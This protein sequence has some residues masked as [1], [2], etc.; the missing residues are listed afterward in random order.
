[1]TTGAWA[2]V[3]REAL[4]VLGRDYQRVLRRGGEAPSPAPAPSPAAAPVVPVT[5]SSAPATPFPS[6][7]PSL[8]T[9]TRFAPRRSEILIKSGGSSLFLPPSPSSSSSFSK[10]QGGLG[11]SVSAKVAESF[12]SDGA[13]TAVLSAVVEGAVSGIGSM[14]GG[15]CAFLGWVFL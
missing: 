2:V 1:M 6:I 11:R 13:S 14:R 12:A 4:L 5:S 10:S 3:L 8:G 15:A 7:T 9:S